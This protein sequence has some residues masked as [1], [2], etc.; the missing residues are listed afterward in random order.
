MNACTVEIPVQVHSK[1]MRL[2]EQGLTSHQT[3]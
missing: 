1:V 3:Q 2:I